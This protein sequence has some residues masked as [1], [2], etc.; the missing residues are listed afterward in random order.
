METKYPTLRRP[1]R[2][3][4]YITEKKSL[5]NQ[6]AESFTYEDV[7]KM[8]DDIDVCVLEP[9]PPSVLFQSSGSGTNYSEGSMSPVPQEEH[10]AEELAEYQISLYHQAPN[11]HV[12]IPS[13]SPILNL[14]TDPTFPFEA[15]RP[16]K[17]SSPIEH[18]PGKETT[19]NLEEE[20]KDDGV[21]QI[22]FNS[23]E[24]TE[25]SEADPVPIQKPQCNGQ[26]AEE[27]DDWE[28]EL[29]ST[30]IVLTKVSS[31]RAVVQNPSNDENIK[32]SVQKVRVEP[33]VGPSTKKS[34]LVSTQPPAEPSSHVKRDMNGFLKQ[35]QLARKSKPSCSKKTPVKSQPRPPLPPE[36]EDDFLI[37]EDDSP[38][39]FS[40]P[41]KS[42]LSKK[43][44]LS[45]NSSAYK[46]SLTDKG[47][48]EGPI[49]VSQKQ[50][51]GE[52]AKN[53]LD[54]QAVNQRTKKKKGKE[55]NREVAES[56]DNKGDFLSHPDLP[57][58][59]FVEQ[60]KP[61]KKKRQKKVLSE[62]T[63]ESE[64]QPKG[65]TNVELE[66]EPA[67]NLKGSTN[68][69]NEQ[70]SQTERS[71]DVQDAGTDDVF[72]EEHQEQ[73][74]QEAAEKGKDMKSEA[75]GEVK[76]D[77]K[78]ASSSGSS[79][80]EAQLSRKR[81][82]QQPG[83]WWVSSP[84]N[85]EQAE[86]PQAPKKSKLK[87]KEPSSAVPSTVMNK[88]DKA[89]AR[90]NSK[91]PTKSSSD[92]TNEVKESKKKPPKRRNAR[93]VKNKETAEKPRRAVA[94]LEEQQIPDQ[95][96]D[97]HSSPLVFSKRDHS[98]NSRGELFQK[99]YHHSSTPASQTCQQKEQ[100]RETEPTKRRRK[101]P[102]DWWAVTKSD[103]LETIDSQP[104][105]NMPKSQQKWEK[106]PKQSPF[107]LGAP[108]NGNVA[109]KTPGGAPEAP[110]KPLS[111]PKVAKR[112][113]ATFKD[114][115]VVVTNRLVHQCKM[116]NVMSQPSV[117]SA[118]TGPITGSRPDAGMHSGVDVDESTQPDQEASQD[119]RCQAEDT[120][121]VFR[122]G[123]S[124]MIDLEK[125]DDDA[126]LPSSR[127]HAVLSVSDF[128]A[129][130]LK[131]L[132][133]QSKDKENITEWFQSLWT[134]EA[135]GD[136]T[137]TPDQFQWYF[138][139]NCAL[140]IQEDFACSTFCAGKL[141][142][143]S[144][145]KKPLWVDHSATTIFNLLTSSVKVTVD[146]SVS[147]YSSGQAFVV[148][149][150]RAYSLQ[151]VNAQPAVLYFTRMLAESLD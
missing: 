120:L 116:H 7:D 118:D 98:L 27:T 54:S 67:Q 4:C 92:D 25:E 77:K 109:S 66:K 132:T 2:K 78:S 134:V 46:E 73:L 99:V 148:E 115:S 135:D 100:L 64:H 45:K 17:T 53:K 91:E 96:L 94:E 39:W 43:E 52:M 145:T 131:P 20:E 18:N 127:V 61:N 14:D 107:R 79:S 137:I 47:T 125:C 111:A 122:S 141:L 34:S 108:K 3:L 128:C 68:A 136:A 75:N 12:Q 51:K 63:D 85:P 95:Q 30:R 88:K 147:R 84:A 60:E 56:D 110:V 28:L 35:I 21:T 72:R 5:S 139:Q 38:L 6:W 144:Y 129:S 44:R 112:S 74:V 55:K 102:S 80:K 70:R 33:E 76:Q 93:D 126:N 149:C 26:V 90:R 22:P 16:I 49:E 36:P 106:R 9:H 123:P 117:E 113:L 86:S 29:P 104:P 142:M 138:Y 151:N 42:G 62:Q 31:H 8:F 105:L 130:P 133:L 87:S 23:E 10:P 32:D 103:D 81:K 65:K 71:E 57:A 59:D 83:D 69:L 140:G 48:N 101:P 24:K 121:R 13:S 114:P 58:D 37:L 124:S 97:E 11:G 15:H 40:I 89:P 143:G 1:R 150:G 146:G 19:E 41:S 50:K 119:R 82:K